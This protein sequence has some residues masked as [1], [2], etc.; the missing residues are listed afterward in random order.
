MGRGGEGIDFVTCQLCGRAFRA[1]MRGHL[2]FRHDFDSDHPVLEYKERF[3]MSHSWSRETR[4]KAI[5]SRIRLNES[6]GSRW[7]RERVRQDIRETV[8]RTGRIDYLRLRRT[9][10]VLT[11]MAYRFFGSWNAAVRA[12][13]FDPK[14]LG[15][16]S[17]WTRESIL[18]EIR[19]R[20]VKKR[21]NGRP[22]DDLL[23]V[24]RRHFGTWGGALRAVGLSPLTTYGKRRW[25]RDEV[26]AELRG[27]AR[28]LPYQEA[29]RR[30]S[31]LVQAAKKY[32]GRWSHAR[33]A[34]GLTPS[35]YELRHHWTRDHVI[36]AVRS[37]GKPV[38]STVA[39]AKYPSLPAAVARHFG[40]WKAAVEAAGFEYPPR[41]WRVRYR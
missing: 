31:G 27:P 37:F 16:R 13:G 14:Q 10:G 19:R 38:S 24:A 35:P 4:E 34:A 41:K 25:T 1:I 2:V 5:R 9:R 6:R 11:L 22:P 21:P 20:Y 26:I 7:T 39:R 30:I 36:Q 17:R 28:S 32:F 15:V 3:G 29:E 18:A 12:S 8:R 33:E 23:S 40:T